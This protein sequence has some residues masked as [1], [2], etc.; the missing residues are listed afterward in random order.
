MNLFFYKL[1]SSL[2]GYPGEDNTVL[3]PP[4]PRGEPV[5]LFLK[6]F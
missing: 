6:L 2:Q 4:G 1:L 3:G 5:G